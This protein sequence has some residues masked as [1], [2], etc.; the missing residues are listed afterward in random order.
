MIFIAIITFAAMAMGAVLPQDG[1]DALV[2]SDHKRG[3]LL[4]R[5]ILN[6]T[7]YG[8]PIDGGR[9]RGAQD[10]SVVD[11]IQAIKARTGDCSMDPGANNCQWLYCNESASVEWCYDSGS[12]VVMKCSDF[13]THL[14]A[15]RRDCSY[16]E[17]YLAVWGRAYDDHDFHVTVE[18]DR[19]G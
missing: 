9:E 2:A 17:D 16:Y 4:S 13:S 1:D 12:P 3:T 18:Y 8:P 19:E 10:S 5:T 15:L 14:E 11:A 7:C 6:T